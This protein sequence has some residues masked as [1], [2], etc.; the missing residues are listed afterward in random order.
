MQASMSM[1][2]SSKRNGGAGGFLQFAP[3]WEAKTKGYTSDICYFGKGMD[4]K[5]LTTSTNLENYI[6]EKYGTTMLSYMTTG[7][8][9]ID[10]EA[11]YERVCQ[12]NDVS[13]GQHTTLVVCIICCCCIVI[14]PLE[15]G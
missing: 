7:K 12:E 9:T 15:H 10:T 13:R 2:S 5:Y 14:R 4:K 1:S 3:T 6:R 11:S 8:M